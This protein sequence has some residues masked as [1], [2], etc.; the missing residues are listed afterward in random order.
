MV[1][2]LFWNFISSFLRQWSHTSDVVDDRH[3]NLFL[4]YY[5]LC[6]R[7]LFRGRSMY[8]PFIK[9]K[10]NKGLRYRSNY[11]SKKFIKKYR[12]YMREAR[13]NETKMNCIFVWQERDRTQQME[14]IISP[15]VRRKE[16]QKNHKCSEEMR[17]RLIESRKLRTFSINKAN[18]TSRISK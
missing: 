16:K 6:Y 1:S 14:R 12:V 11:M 15:V 8:R 17:N 13:M 3:F 5:A 10:I 18:K 9:Q 4:S 2:C 7:A